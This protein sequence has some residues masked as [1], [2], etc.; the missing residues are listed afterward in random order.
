MSKAK[1][2]QQRIQSFF[3]D[4]LRFSAAATNTPRIEIIGQEKM[5]VFQCFTIDKYSEC[6]IILTTP[7]SKISIIGMCL[8]LAAFVDQTVE[9]TGSFHSL[10]FC[11]KEDSHPCS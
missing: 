8:S 5:T 9:I 10:Q 4:T 6:E 2:F 11:S 1:K 7:H 3:C